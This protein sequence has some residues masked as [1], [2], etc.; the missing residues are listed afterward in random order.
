MVRMG[1]RSWLWVLVLAVQTWACGDERA[2][3][4]GTVLVGGACVADPK[5]LVCGSGTA[6]DGGVC[7]ALTGGDTTGGDANVG[8]D[9][10][11]ETSGSDALADALADTVADAVADA[12]VVDTAVDT[13]DEATVC[14]PQCLGKA[15]GD[16]GCGGNC[17]KCTTAEAPY[18]NSFTGLCTAVCVPDCVAKNCGPDSCGGS[19]GTCAAKLACQD[20]GR[21]VPEAWTCTPT[22]YDG[23]AVCHCGCGAPDP[24]CAKPNPALAGCGAYEQCN[25]NGA[26]ESTVPEK[27]LCAKST[28]NALDACH[29][30]CGAPDPDCSVDKL[31]TFG[32]KGA[33]KCEASGVCA[34]CTPACAGKVC[35]DDGCGGL[36][37]TCPES[38]AACDNGTCVDAC[39]PTPLLCKTNQCGPDSC[40]GSCGSCGA[41]ANCA[42]GKC[43]A[44]PPAEDPSSCKGHCGGAALAGCYCTAG[45]AA[46]GVCCKDYAEFC[47]CTPNCKDKACGY[48]G[49]GGVCG[50]CSKEKPTCG[51]DFQCTDKCTPKCNGV[52]CGDDGCGGTCGLCKPDSTCAWTQQCVPN[53]W[54]C[55]A[56]YYADQLGCD[57]S[58]GA[59]DP[60]C[61]QAGSSTY[62]CPSAVACGGDG[63]CLMPVCSAN[64]ECKNQW[65]VGK[66]FAGG[67]KFAGA[68][69]TPLPTAF[70]PGQPCQFDLQ[71]ASELCVQGSCRQYCKVEADCP[72]YH[73]CV[74][75]ATV[76][77]AGAKG[78][79]GVCHALPGSLT[80]CKA[81]ADCTPK[82]E[83]CVAHIDPATLGAKHLC[84]ELPQVAFGASCQ[85]KS[86]PA[87]H[88]C[89]AAK[90]KY[91]CT[92]PCPG[93]T[94]D[95]PSG[96]SCGTA[97]LHDNGTADQA[98]DPKVAAC[99]PN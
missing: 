67:A 99:V 15:C 90:Q 26:C 19:C 55:D 28:Y 58:C 9:T 54:Q 65:C 20:F 39:K 91:Q 3:G 73:A 7:I 86:C 97:T 68:C 34:A 35:G 72:P 30:G 50:A 24:D 94:T 64:S 48:D 53:A 62:G 33:A 78:F 95:C 71:C 76:S 31:P 69:A 5:L 29:C 63:K 14:A 51:T 66:W 8:P 36:C 16:D 82:A 57:C 40:G 32:C 46:A 85:V 11:G 22:T 52:Q 6:L 10:A 44:D 88:L 98:D 93:G 4:A 87:G 47:T 27:W 13:A 92:L 79:A 23:D 41:G 18:C 70:A 38:A 77:S 80:P 2:C 75:L 43:V 21:C 42:G 12:A 96:W 49:C 1:M 81:K 61:K 45:C 89:I 83:Q 59:P 56:G 37:G 84:T 25:K 74:G 60:D 17:G